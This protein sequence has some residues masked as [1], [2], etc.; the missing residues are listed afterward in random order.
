MTRLSGLLPLVQG[1]AAWAALNQDANTKI[2]AGDSRTRGQIMADTLIERVT[3]QAT[4]DQVPVEVNL[5]LPA[6]TLLARPGHPGRDEP[7]IIPGHGPVPAAWA[8]DLIHTSRAP[9]WLRRLFTAPN[10]GELVAM[11]SRRRCF[12]KGQREFIARRD[13][14]CRTPW[15]DAPIR[16]TDHIQPHETGGPTTSTTHR[17]TAKPATTPNKPPA[18]T[19]K[20][21]HT[22][23][24]TPST[25]PPPPHT[26]TKAAP[27]THPAQQ[28]TSHPSKSKSPGGSTLRR[29]SRPS[30]SAV[31]SES[32]VSTSSGR[33]R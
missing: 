24:D 21:P 29:N 33:T 26:A 9:V 30:Q 2:A 7:A 17:A 1:V 8:R 5:L 18:G 16:H 32:A 4:A 11:D 28:P 25:S 10:T 22:P 23:T 3:G 14:T 6:D 20:S 15:C 13:Q 31:P 12:T 27:P 19:P